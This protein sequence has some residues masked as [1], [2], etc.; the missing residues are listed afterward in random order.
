VIRQLVR[1]AASPSTLVA[2]FA[3]V[4]AL[5]ATAVAVAPRN[6][7]TSAGIQDSTI[8]SS[9]VKNSSLK[10]LDIA[11]RTITT[12]DVALRGLYGT[13]IKSDTVTGTQVKE[14]TLAEVPAAT[15]ADKAAGFTRILPT[16]APATDAADA[17]TG[18][19]NAPLITLATVGS[20]KLQAKCF[21][22]TGADTIHAEVYAATTV[23]G[24]TFSSTV[25]DL[26]GGGTVNATSFLNVASAL[27]DRQVL[28][29]AQGNDIARLSDLTSESPLNMFAIDGTWVQGNVSAFVRNGAPAGASSTFYG[30]EHS[31]AFFGDLA[32]SGTT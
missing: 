28:V 21:H 16:F 27:D 3:I 26:V 24:A 5:A 25:D 20:L 7:V 32:Y 29:M 6:W 11:S 8:T 18:R 17:A 13:N 30:T 2:A 15:L 10:G 12:S 4:I 19:A 23:D 22:A 9:D 1:R 31:C 14:S